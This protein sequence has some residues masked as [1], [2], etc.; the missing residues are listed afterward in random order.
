[1]KH[2]IHFD[3]FL[4]WVIISELNT[5]KLSLMQRYD[6]NNGY[7]E[8]KLLTHI[9]ILCRTLISESGH[10]SLTLA[11]FKEIAKS[12]DNIAENDVILLYKIL[13]QDSKQI[14]L[15]MLCY[16]CINLNM[17]SLENIM[18]TLYKSDSTHCVTYDINPVP[19][20]NIF[21]SLHVDIPNT[22]EKS[23]SIHNYDSSKTPPPT[24]TDS[25]KQNTAIAEMRSRYKRK[26][27]VN[28]TRLRNKNTSQSYLN[29]FLI[30]IGCKS[31]KKD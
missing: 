22:T 30:W 17:Y 6:F 12:Y 14:S 23:I 31:N 4:N 27:K 5:E 13:A 9:R 2:K 16:F 25:Y 21:Q 10:K 18:Q 3:R 1:M 26:T 15:R 20:V 24:P 29:Q 28:N 8:N 19:N 11:M 7:G